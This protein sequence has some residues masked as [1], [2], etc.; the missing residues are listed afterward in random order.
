MRTVL[1]EIYDWG[2]LFINYAFVF[3]FILFHGFYVAKKRIHSIIK[4][5]LLFSSNELFFVLFSQFFSTGFCCC[6]RSLHRFR[7]SC[8][9]LIFIEYDFL[10]Y[11][12]HLHPQNP[13]KELYYFSLPMYKF[14]LWMQ[15]KSHKFSFIKMWAFVWFFSL[16]LLSTFLFL[17]WLCSTVFFVCNSWRCAASFLVQFCGANL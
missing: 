17:L 7:S 2:K 13:Q 11:A 15:V 16:I 12:Q 10:L 8:F 1:I 14:H 3:F 9:L 4:F 5:V 6:C